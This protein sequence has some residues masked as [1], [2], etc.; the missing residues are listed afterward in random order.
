MFVFLIG[1]LTG[2]ALANS[3][4]NGVFKKSPTTNSI[5]AILCSI[6]SPLLETPPK[7]SEK[8][9]CIF[10]L[11]FTSSLPSLVLPV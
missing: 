11:I 4:T 6:D 2:A 9:V 8:F 3:F 1:D 5:L 10:K 7:S